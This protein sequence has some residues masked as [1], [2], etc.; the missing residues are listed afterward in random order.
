[1][2]TKGFFVTILLSFLISPWTIFSLEI[3]K[4]QWIS[5]PVLGPPVHDI[6]VRNNDS[7]IVYIIAG[8][9]QR[10]FKTQ[11]GGLSWEYLPISYTDRIT[12]LATPLCID[13]DP[14]SVDT[15][16]V[17]TKQGLFKSTDGGKNWNDLSGGVLKWKDISWIKLIDSNKIYVLSEG[18]IYKTLNGG[19]SWGDISPPIEIDFITMHSKSEEIYAINR[20]IIPSQIFYSDD[21]GL[22]WKKKTFKAKISE[23]STR[24]KK[25]YY[26]ITNFEELRI[27]PLNN[28]LLFALG[29]TFG[30]D[31]HLLKSYD[32]GSTWEDIT[33]EKNN[34]IGINIRFGD[35][36]EDKF[37]LFFDSIDENFLY[38][39]G[40]KSRLPSGDWIYLI[41][42]T[43]DGGHTWEF[44]PVKI[45]MIHKPGKQME[46]YEISTA[47]DPSIMYAAT[48]QGVYKTKDRGKSWRPVNIGL[49]LGGVYSDTNMWLYLDKENPIFYHIIDWNVQDEVVI[50]K[51][52]DGGITW[53]EFYRD[54]FR[55]NYEYPHAYLEHAIPLINFKG[56]YYLLGFANSRIIKTKARGSSEWKTI[57]TDAIAPLFFGISESNP[58]NF[59]LLDKRNLFIS[60]DG[61]FSW[62]SVRL[63]RYAKMADMKIIDDPKIIYILADGAIYKSEDKGMNWIN[64]TPS[65][66]ITYNQRSIDI[67]TFK[68]DPSFPNILYLG[69]DGQGIY[70]ST[71][72]GKTWKFIKSFEERAKLEEIP[73]SNIDI[74][75]IAIDPK[76]P[77]IL[78]VGTNK[79]VFKSLDKGATW[80]IFNDGLPDFDRDIK[81][82][83]INNSN[84]Q[85]IVLE[86]T[87]GKNIWRL[88]DSSSWNIMK[89]RWE[90]IWKK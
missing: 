16:Y 10:L 30:G 68:V 84:P 21:G 81:T 66:H 40:V 45:G 20:K 3:N 37:D 55:G 6:L 62:F 89:E 39:K 82:I 69:T 67:I 59:Y 18:R 74:N 35:L 52:E 32:G 58:N 25:N 63:P 27:S 47:P 56:D 9:K 14:T 83:M 24:G 4:E 49:P 22:T 26:D 46:V 72:G 87:K 54:R 50:Y 85:L 13:E 61:G 15:I 79:G 1:M 8:K 77:N 64:I 80:K 78:Y 19:K 36:K 51:S 43:T 33:P 42:R 11:N 60:E 65:W 23:V 70:I 88:I 73:I 57:K 41:L 76:N 28:K 31:D 48:S 34:I 12:Q 7:N 75:S 29:E 53:E 2:R 44:L 86:T 38:L 71:N 17:G 5:I 90:T